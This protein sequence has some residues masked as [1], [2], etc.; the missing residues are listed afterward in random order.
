MAVSMV[1]TFLSHSSGKQLRQALEASRVQ[2]VA[3]RV[4]ASASVDTRTVV[5]VAKEITG[6]GGGCP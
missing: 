5:R 3:N 1:D 4:L 6:E 2:I